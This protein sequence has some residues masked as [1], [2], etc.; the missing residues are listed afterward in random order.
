M[1]SSLMSNSFVPDTGYVVWLEFNPQ[2]GNEQARN[3]LALVF[4]PASYKGKTEL[5][6][7]CS[8]FT[9]IKGHP[10]EVITQLDGV[11]CAVL[12]MKSNPWT[13]E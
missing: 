11:V 2:I 6:V 8:F 9:K 13:G 1:S 12:L 3:R 5:M 4:N 7:C 10:F